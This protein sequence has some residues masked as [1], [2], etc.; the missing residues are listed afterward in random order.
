[1]ATRRDFLRTTA[2]A[3]LSSL[4]LAPSFRVGPDIVRFDPQIEPLVRWLEETPRERLVAGLLGKIH[5]G[6]T[7]REGMAATFLAAIRNIKPRPVG[8]KFHAVMAVNSARVMAQNAPARD[9]WLTLFWAA[10]NFKDSQ[11]RDIEE[12]DWTLAAVDEAHLPS[13]DKARQTLIEALEN[14]DAVKADT[15]TAALVRSAQPQ[16]VIKV[17]FR[18]GIRDQRNIGH[19]PIFTMQCWRTLEAIGWQH[20]E[21]VLRSLAFGLLDT[22][23][24]NI[25]GPVGPY[26][27]NLELVASIKPDYRGGQLDPSA[28]ESLL[29]TLLTESSDACA[30]AVVDALDKGVDARSAWDAILLAASELLVRAPGIIALHAVTA[31]NSLHYIHLN[32]PDELT[33]KLALL[34][35]AGWIPLY[36]ER[37][38][39]LPKSTF[40]RQPDGEPATLEAIFD[41]LKSNRAEAARMAVATLKQPEQS[42]AFLRD[43]HRRIIH[44]GRDSHQFK[45]GT[46]AAEEAA[47]ADD[48]NAHSR[49]AAAMLAYIPDGS[50][51]PN[52]LIAEALAGLPEAP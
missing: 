39:K 41:R 48:R 19:K 26:R 3:G 7:Y 23:G 25:D 11:A 36:R 37:I 22:Q 5:D 24:D 31:A 16:D 34:Q 9:A 10:D 52:P 6:M 42:Q 51:P 18:F 21:P 45:Y 15:A 33:S 27:S 47:F 30:H 49:I 40:D 13:P 46:A 4:A 20:A 32:G 38:G 35:A 2:G 1:M 12:G 44:N 43:A 29:N 17:F 28:T 50:E 14:W 8:F